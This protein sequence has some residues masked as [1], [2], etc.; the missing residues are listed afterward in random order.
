[1]PKLT[2]AEI[3]SHNHHWQQQDADYCGGCGGGSEWP[4]FESRALTE[5]LV[6]RKVAAEIVAFRERE[7][8]DDGWRDDMQSLDAAL[9]EWE[10]L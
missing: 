2:D 10:K 1:M 8:A 3:A 5:L 9:A 6:L 7:L 4:C